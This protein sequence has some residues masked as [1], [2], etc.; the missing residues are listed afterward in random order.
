MNKYSILLDYGK[1][2]KTVI[3]ARN[4]ESTIN[5]AIQWVKKENW[6][7]FDKDEFMMDKTVYIHITIR[8]DIGQVVNAFDQRIDP[9]EPKCIK[10][11]HDWDLISNSNELLEKCNKC[12]LYITTLWKNDYQYIQYSRPKGDNK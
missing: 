1:N 7:D 11:E 3:S 4:D 9:P 10:G 5:K 12:G 6:F 2:G 8:N